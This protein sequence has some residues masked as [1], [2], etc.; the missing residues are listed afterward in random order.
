MTTFLA[1]HFISFSEY[2]TQGLIASLPVRWRHFLWDFWG[3]HAFITTQTYIFPVVWMGLGE[4]GDHLGKHT[5][6]Q[7]CIILWQPT[8][9]TFYNS[10]LERKGKG[11][12][13]CW[14]HHPLRI[15][16]AQQKRPWRPAL[17]QETHESL[18][19]RFLPPQ[20]CRHELST[21]VKAL[22]N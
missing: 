11:E 2:S 16:P 19:T 12:K 4:Y 10:D 6:I 13:W 14:V 15:G 17:F 3:F 5:D 7:H 8:T 20:C 22:I 21:S 1:T 18:L 9:I